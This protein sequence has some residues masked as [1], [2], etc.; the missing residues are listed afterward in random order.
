MADSASRAPFHL[1][2]SQEYSGSNGVALAD[3]VDL[4]V[5]R[6]IYAAKVAI[7]ELSMESLRSKYQPDTKQTHIYWGG[8]NLDK[9]VGCV[10]RYVEPGPA[11]TSVE[12]LNC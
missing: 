4:C 10:A 3:A 7:N 6:S 9:E 8:T 11:P 12:I 5:S 2:K 1:V